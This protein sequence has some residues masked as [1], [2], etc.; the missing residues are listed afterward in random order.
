MSK[1]KNY[2]NIRIKFDKHVSR[3]GISNFLT[4]NT[5][6][7]GRAIYYKGMFFILF[8]QTN[9]VY[10]CDRRTEWWGEP[11]IRETIYN[12]GEMK[13]EITACNFQGLICP[14]RKIR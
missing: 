5:H 4:K 10:I 13:G 14:C 7:S 11:V 3:I 9:A 8:L 6:I 2:A 12:L 1:F